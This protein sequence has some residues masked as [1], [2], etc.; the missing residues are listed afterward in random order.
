M[1]IVVNQ[2][3]SVNWYKLVDGETMSYWG[4]RE[5]LLSGKNKMFKNILLKSIVN[6]FIS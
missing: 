6:D 4:N 2:S 3:F 5:T 1:D